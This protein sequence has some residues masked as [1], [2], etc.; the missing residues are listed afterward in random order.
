MVT[1]GHWGRR[2][3][4]RWW[5]R[6]RRW[7]WGWGGWRNVGPAVGI[8][9]A[10]PLRQLHEVGSVALVGAELVLADVLDE[11]DVVQ[12]ILSEAHRGARRPALASRPLLG[13]ADVHLDVG[14]PPTLGRPRLGACSHCHEHVTVLDVLDG[15]CG[16][17][18]GHCELDHYRAHWGLHHLFDPRRSWCRRWR[19]RRWRARRWRGRRWSRWGRRWWGRTGA[20][21]CRLA[22]AGV[23]PPAAS[24]ALLT[25]TGASLH[26]PIVAHG[27][28]V[29]GRHPTAGGG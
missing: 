17:F 12:A 6:R 10:E 15:I 22:A 24:W 2:R 25:G 18:A 29:G 27:R 7:A 5:R 21:A 19:G 26:I 13:P 3:R 4:R 28:T 9:D 8:A 16:R 14:D 11:E 1:T 20:A 23:F